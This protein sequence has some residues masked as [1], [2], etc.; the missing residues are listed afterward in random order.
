MKRTKNEQTTL[1]GLTTP[2]EAIVPTIGGVPI[3]LDQDSIH[4]NTVTITPEYAEHLLLGYNDGNRP[5][6]KRVWETYAR[7]MA[8]GHWSLTGEAIILDRDGKLLDGQHRLTACMMSK[9]PFTTVLVTGVDRNSAFLRMGMGEKRRASHVLA[10]HG[11]TNTKVLQAAAKLVW[12]Y[13]L[14][15]LAQ[16]KYYPSNSEIE[17][18]VRNNPKLAEYVSQSWLK[19]IPGPGS[20]VAA[21]RYLFGMADEKAADKFFESLRT[22]AVGTGDS[23]V[24]VLRDKLMLA[25]GREKLSQYETVAIFVKAWN[26]FILGKS[27]GTLKFA[28]TGPRAESMPK[29]LGLQVPLENS[30]A[31]TH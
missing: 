24:R 3:P 30:T 28:G 12:T 29:V 1:D 22:G 6:A 17:D 13:Q 11:F 18:V 20:I 15:S 5:L 23:P 27:M 10:I 16:T 8:A 25:K 31:V 21:L 14:G 7:D 4:T 2:T 26:A 19:G 9:V